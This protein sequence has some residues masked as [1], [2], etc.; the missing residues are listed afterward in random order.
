M[1]SKKGI[2]I[3]FSVVFISSI[4]LTGCSKN[5]VKNE[6]EI[7]V[8]RYGY[9]ATNSDVLSGLAGIAVQEGYFEEEFK[10]IN[11]EFQG[12]PFVK[13]GPAINSALISGELEAAGLGDVP[14]IVAKAQGGS[15][16]L[17][18]IQPSEYSTHLI[19]A[20]DSDVMEVKDLKGKKVAVQTGSYM[21]R[22][23][24]Q[25][26]EKNGIDVSEV[27][28]LNMSEVEAAT[29]IVAGSIDATAVT[30]MKGIKLEQD[31]NARLL[32][33]TEGEPNMQRLSAYVVRS[34]FAK[35]HPEVVTAYFK[36]LIR[37]QEYAQEHPEDL[38][39]LYIKSGLEESIVDLTYPEVSD[40]IAITGT[41]EENKDI[42]QNVITFLKNNELITSDVDLSAWFDDS[43][44]KQAKSEVDN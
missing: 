34:D 18:N 3:V 24:Y 35:E 25:I 39:D 22:I 9:T 23:L 38:R 1:K 37:A 15:T 16:T 13:A 10:E 7:T 12:I 27:E 2:A 26:F 44:Y 21:Q 41:T 5:Q 14:A 4:W 36:A 6:D 31:G 42:M 43:F 17:V 32:Y 11:V 29:A 30:E 19:V 8:F 40:Y 33:D 20:K 28:L